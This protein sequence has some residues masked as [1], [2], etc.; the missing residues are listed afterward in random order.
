MHDRQPSPSV[1]DDEMNPRGS[2][3]R[4]KGR[5]GQGRAGSVGVGVCF[6]T[7]LMSFFKAEGIVCALFSCFPFFFQRDLYFFR[8]SVKG[9]QGQANVRSDSA[10]ASR[11]PSPV[12]FFFFLAISIIT[13]RERERRKDGMLGRV[14]CQYD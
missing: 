13:E 4:F 12:F 11:L 9:E 7:H 10:R 5:A 2:S 1:G 6:N 8:A 3:F 14:Y